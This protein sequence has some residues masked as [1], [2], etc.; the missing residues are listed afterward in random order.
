MRHFL[1]DFDQK[2]K[3]NA[4]LDF[5][6]FFSPKRVSWRGHVFWSKDVIFL[7]YGNFRP[8]SEFGHF[9]KYINKFWI[10]FCMSKIGII[11]FFF[12]I[13]WHNLYTNEKLALCRLKAVKGYLLSDLYFFPP[14]PPS[15]FLEE[16]QPWPKTY[17]NMLHG[18]HK[19]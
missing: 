19:S 12:S 9:G 2:S 3:K 16:S 4:Y 18:L 6:Y 14:N 1:I 5:I 13:T 7:A 11:E 10:F 15:L 17:Q 8:F